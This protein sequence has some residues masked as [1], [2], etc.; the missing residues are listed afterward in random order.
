[1]LGK[2]DFFMEHFLVKLHLP[3]IVAS[4]RTHIFEIIFD[5]A[6]DGIAMVTNEPFGFI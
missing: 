1:M 5:D 3:H 2:S 6:V 4:V